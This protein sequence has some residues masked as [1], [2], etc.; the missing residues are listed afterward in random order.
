M[1]TVVARALV[2]GGGAETTLKYAVVCLFLFAA[3]G[4]IIGMLAE[5]TIQEA[6]R[7][8]LSVEL[9]ALAAETDSKDMA[10]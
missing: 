2:H 4:W 10:N 7:R 1:V 5:Q 9:Q 6:A 8:R 3:I